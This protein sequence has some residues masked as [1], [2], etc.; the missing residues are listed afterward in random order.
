MG[1]MGAGPWRDGMSATSAGRFG[2]YRGMRM[3]EQGYLCWSASE[4]RIAAHE[5]DDQ[6]GLVIFDYLNPRFA[7]PATVREEA[8]WTTQRWIYT[9]PADGSLLGQTI[10]TLLFPGALFEWRGSRFDWW[11]Y[12]LAG[13]NVGY[14]S[15]AGYR[16]IGPGECKYPTFEATGDKAFAG[17]WMI[18]GETGENPFPLLF[19]FE[20][21][22]VRVT[23]ISRSQSIEFDGPAGWIAVC[24]LTGADRWSREQ[25]KRLN[26]PPDEKLLATI[27]TL[28]RLK[29]AAPVKCTERFRV[30]L[31]RDVVEVEQTFEHL[32]LSDAFGTKPLKIAPMSPWLA[33][34][35]P[36]AKDLVG[37][38]PDLGLR[39]EGEVIDTGIATLWG[40]YLGAPG[41]VLR[42]SMK[43]S[44]GMNQT[45]APVRVTGDPRCDEL[46]KR[47]DT[48]I[49]E[50]TL[51]FGGDN[52]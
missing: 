4:T 27:E 40:P 48:E 43:R 12:D 49:A 38:V 6:R 18:V 37:Q 34:A 50:P 51:T 10:H 7:G 31:G 47:L 33:V 32:E 11:N 9:N 39:V 46:Q 36:G 15:R 35:C 42:Y 45:I 24:P 23:T 30:D 20:K 2:G 29:L 8:D 21:P 5:K 44:W 16:V 22:P 25:K 13:A 14:P 17:P 41:S 1:A 19:L 28:A 26:S 52:T 3:P